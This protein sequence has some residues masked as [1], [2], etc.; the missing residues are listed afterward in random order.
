MKAI[1][2]FLILLFLVLYSC[3]L[4]NGKEQSPVFENDLDRIRDRGKLTVLTDYSST[5]Y[6]IY[7]GQPLGYQY[8]ML[9]NLAEYLGVRLEVIVSH[10]LD[11][12]FRLLQKGEVDLIAQNLTV[13]RE[14]RQ[15]VD[16]T[17]PLIQ[18]RQVLVQLKPQNWSQMGSKEIESLIITNPLD[19]AEKSIY[20]TKGSAYV[21]RL[22]HLSEEI[23]DSIHIVEVDE[24][25]EQLIQ[26]VADGEIP[27]TVCDEIIA[28]VNSMYH[29]ELEVSTPVSLQQNMAWAVRKGSVQFL[30]ELNVW[31]SDFLQT[32]RYKIIYAKY[33][34]R[35]KPVTFV[36]NDY[37]AINSGI[38]SPFDEYI[39]AY[40]ELV[41]WDWRLLTSLIYQE[42]RFKVNAVSWAGAFGI[43]QLMPATARQYGIIPESPPKDQIRAGIQYIKWLDNYYEDIQDPAERIK[44]VLAAYNV[45]QGHVNDARNLARK[46]G[47]DPDTWDNNVDQYL[48]LKSK[49]E[50]YNDPVVKYGYCRGTETYRYVSEVL[51]RYEHY[52][53]VVPE[54][55][56]IR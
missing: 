34:T 21:P 44:F 2:S 23:G 37:F 41:E 40:S 50:F 39:K 42:S 6:Y 49:P 47:V 22:H 38:I 56:E 51:T 27:Y 7:R 17:V 36:E 3:E 8:E 45:G 19:L 32:N 30:G 25:V 9:Q 5:D 43:M 54:D 10:N 28:H 12:G 20:V 11:E 1:Y 52:K 4:Q 33:Y 15:Q 18:T 48:L 16:F 13:T 31:L 29:P 55:L 14:R 35:K 46:N 26:L 53:N 24:R